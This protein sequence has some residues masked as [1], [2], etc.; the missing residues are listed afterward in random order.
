MDPPF[1][2]DSRCLESLFEEVSYWLKEVGQGLS[3]HG[4][5]SLHLAASVGFRP[6]KGPQEHHLNQC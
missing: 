1:F 3:K 6:L 5:N 2:G 4:R